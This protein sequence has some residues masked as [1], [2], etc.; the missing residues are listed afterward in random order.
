MAHQTKGLVRLKR[1]LR[2]RQITQTQIAAQAGVTAPHVN[3][4]L[5]G[6]YVSAKV[7]AA[8]RQLLSRGDP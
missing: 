1:R 3:N 4:V 7:V 5:A 6:R 8:A 2:R